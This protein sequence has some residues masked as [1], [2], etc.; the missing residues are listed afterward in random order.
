MIIRG[1][2]PADYTAVENLVRQAFYNMYRPGC[3]EHFLVRAL[4]SHNDFVAALDL[5]AEEA[6]EI[7]GQVMCTK[8]TLVGEDGTRLSALTLGPI[9]V[10]PAQQRKGIGKQLIAQAAEKAKALGYA[11]IVLIG[12][13]A[14]YV[15]SGFV[16]CKRWQ[17]A[18][19]DGRYP[20]AMLVRPLASD[21]LV[22]ARWTY[23]ESPAFAIDEAA[24][25]HYD[26]TL[27]PME[28]RWQ[29]SQEEFYILSQAFLD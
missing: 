22:G 16:S 27:P 7:V 13:P 8:A 14:N 15:A 12:S 4:R 24:A 23:Y 17:L 5:V 9:S 6:G 1:E 19:P 18:T 3:V 21:A 29:P 2:T 26:A 28:K 10:A 25:E 20:A 11:A